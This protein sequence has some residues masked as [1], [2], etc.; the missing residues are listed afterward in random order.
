VIEGRRR[1]PPAAAAHLTFLGACVAPANV[2]FGIEGGGS[3]LPVHF[4]NSRQRATTSLTSRTVSVPNVN[5]GARDRVALTLRTLRRPS[6][7]PPLPSR[8]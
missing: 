4:V 3:G 2:N 7:M 8:S 6:S 1:G 5:T